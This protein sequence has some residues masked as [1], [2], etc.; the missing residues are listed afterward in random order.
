MLFGYGRWSK[1]RS[2]SKHADKLLANKSDEE[3]RSYS[4][5]FLLHLANNLNEKPDTQDKLLRLIEIK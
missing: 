5:M 3:L 1:I 4:N 2:V